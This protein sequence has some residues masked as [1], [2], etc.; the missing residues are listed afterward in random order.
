MWA[1]IATPF[2]TAYAVR[3]LRVPD[4]MIGLYLG[5]NVGASLVSNVLW[6]WMSLRRGHRAVL[7]G[8]TLCGLLSALWALLVGPLSRP[9]PG[10]SGWLMLLVFVLS[11]A[12]ASGAAIGGMSMLLEI[13]P[14]HDRPLTIGLTNTLL[15]I[16]LLSTSTGGL[17]ADLIGYRGL[18]ALSFGFYTLALVL[19]WGLKRAMEPAA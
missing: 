9:W 13:A 17:I 2:F 19:L 15:G 12:Y 4:A 1:A 16:A 6:S 5:F 7:E 18:F 14:G 3:E 8:A 11:G 10:L